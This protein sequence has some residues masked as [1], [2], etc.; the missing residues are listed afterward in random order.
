M[1]IAYYFPVDFFMTAERQIAFTKAA[2]VL[3][4]EVAW[5]MADLECR[6]V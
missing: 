1:G 2:Q 4:Q 6:C 5:T 3:I